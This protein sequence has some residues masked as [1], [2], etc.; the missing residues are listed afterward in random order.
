M[1]HLLVFQGHTWR[2]S[3]LF[4]VVAMAVR[5]NV[6]RLMCAQNFIWMHPIFGIEIRDLVVVTVAAVPTR[7]RFSL[8][9]GIIQFPHNYFW[10]GAGVVPWPI[11]SS[12]R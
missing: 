6:T 7:F 2:G 9:S 10:V 11:Y 4:V 5:I 8:L 12:S 1:L 3:L